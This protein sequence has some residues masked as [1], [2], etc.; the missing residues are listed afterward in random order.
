MIKGA[1]TISSELLSLEDILFNH[2]VVEGRCFSAGFFSLFICRLSQR[3]GLFNLIL[4]LFLIN[5]NTAGEICLCHL[6]HA[7]PPELNP[8]FNFAI[9]FT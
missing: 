1:V 3:Y 6:C 8:F 7:T 2:V 9:I 4:S 5:Q